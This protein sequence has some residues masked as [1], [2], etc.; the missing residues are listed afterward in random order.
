MYHYFIFLYMY[1]CERWKQ[2]SFNIYLLRSFKKV[3]KDFIF[4]NIHSKVLYNCHFHFV[5]TFPIIIF[6]VW[7]QFWEVSW[8]AE[9]TVQMYSFVCT[10]R[11]TLLY[12][13]SVPVEHSSASSQLDKSRDIQFILHSIRQDVGSRRSCC[14]RSRKTSR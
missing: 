9:Q 8:A 3:F 1:K 11:P 14:W 2:K 6:A 7:S 12:R 10:M 4:N 5:S 13:I